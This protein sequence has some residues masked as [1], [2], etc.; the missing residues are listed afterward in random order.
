VDAGVDDGDLDPG[1]VQLGRGPGVGVLHLARRPAARGDRDVLSRSAARPRAVRP[2]GR[3][4]PW[5]LGRE[6]T[7]RSAAPSLGRSG[8]QALCRSAALS[9]GRS[10][11]LPLGR[12]VALPL[13]GRRSAA[14]RKTDGGGAGEATAARSVTG[15][16]PPV[17]SRSSLPCWTRAGCGSEADLR[18]SSATGRGASEAT[19]TALPKR[20]PRS[21][22]GSAIRASPANRAAAVA[23]W[24]RR[25]GSGG[26]SAM[27]AV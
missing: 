14:Q 13:S 7:G 11:A 8:A 9:L 3:P 23:I 6:R 2:R 5:P 20:L 18:V 10:V 19:S 27:L 24:P 26:P 1:R 25:Y 4:G 16:A 12:S 15:A 17:K 21:T 22:A